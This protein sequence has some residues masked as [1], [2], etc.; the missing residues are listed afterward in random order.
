MTMVVKTKKRVAVGA[1]ANGEHVVSPDAHADETDRD[2]CG[3]H[4]GIAE[5]GLARKDRNDLGGESEAGNDEDVD[6]G[7]AEDPE[8]M[9]PEDSGAA[10]LR[11]KEVRA[12]EAIEREHDLGSGERR[13]DDEDQSTHDEVEPGKQGHFTEGHTGTAETN[14]GGD[15]VDGGADAADSRRRGD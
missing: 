15:N 2:S 6:F 12:E 4:D 3:N 7:M 13:D 14:D 9:H 10:G 5:D 1:H 11:V 8:E